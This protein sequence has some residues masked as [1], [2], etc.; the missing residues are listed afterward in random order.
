[1]GF[2]RN[3]EN[4]QGR[5]VVRHLHHCRIDGTLHNCVIASCALFRQCSD[6]RLAHYAD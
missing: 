5:S 4:G 6:S 3:G 1:M 2:E